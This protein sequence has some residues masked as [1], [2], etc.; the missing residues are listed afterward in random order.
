M[1]RIFNQIK[2]N[3]RAAAHLLQNNE[4]STSSQCAAA[5]TRVLCIVRMARHG[6]SEHPNTPASRDASK[7]EATAEVLASQSG[8]TDSL[9][10]AT[11]GKHSAKASRG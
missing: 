2:T 10:R 1:Q 11:C 9:A 8:A 7:I 4:S 5:T 3:T 6:D